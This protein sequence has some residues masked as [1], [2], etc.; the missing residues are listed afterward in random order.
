M[1]DQALNTML[2]VVLLLNFFTLMTSRL[3]TAITLYV[4][5]DD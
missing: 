1:F 3:P 4:G 5:T 2:V